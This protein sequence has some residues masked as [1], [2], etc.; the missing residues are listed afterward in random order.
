MESELEDT[1]WAAYHASR[2]PESCV[3]CPTALLP[4]FL[5]SAHKHSM[6]VVNSAVNHLN[7]GQTPVIT[8]DQ[9]L[10]I[11]FGKADTMEVAREIWR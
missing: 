7:P 4:L 9:P 6:D 5:E 8:F 10:Y 1:S 11:S 3:I 2:Q